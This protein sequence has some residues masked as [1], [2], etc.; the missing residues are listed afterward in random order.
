MANTR[1]YT[2]EELYIATNIVKRAIK[3]QILKGNRSTI[4]K[5]EVFDLIYPKLNLKSSRSLWRSTHIEYLNKWY[6]E[7]EKEVYDLVNKNKNI[8][9]LVLSQTLKTGENAKEIIVEKDKY[10]IALEARIKEL[11]IENEALRTAYNGKY[12]KIDLEQ[13]IEFPF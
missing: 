7:L 3:N 13:G 8:K 9:Q 2:K 12:T 10:I 11:V 4:T 1:K 5:S 6:F